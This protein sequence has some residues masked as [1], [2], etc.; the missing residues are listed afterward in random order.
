MKLTKQQT[1]HILAALWF[2][3]DH[4]LFHMKQFEGED[5]G[6]LNHREIQ[7]LSEALVAPDPEII[8]LCGS[9]KFKEVFLKAQ[10]EFTL[11]GVIVLSVGFFGHADGWEDSE[12]LK[13]LLDE[14]HLRK[15]D[16][17]DAVFVLNEGGYIGE[18][19]AR[20]IEYAVR[21]SLPVNYLEPIKGE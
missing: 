3:Q 13:P 15:I 10:K 4:Q 14:L 16:M 6:P 5:F 11:K 1:A 9:T 18:S 19:T 8:C 2:T 20:E 7:E 21:K 17:A 12:H